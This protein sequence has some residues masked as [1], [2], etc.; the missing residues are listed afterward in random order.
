MKL[1]VLLKRQAEIDK[2]IHKLYP[3]YC[4]V[5]GVANLAKYINTKPRVMFVLKEANDYYES[6]RSLHSNN[7]DNVIHGYRNWRRSYQKLLYVA[8]G[9]LTQ[10][11]LWNDMDDL[12]ND[13]TID[14]YF[15]LDEIAFINLK[16][17]CGGSQANLTEVWEEY[18][19]AR[20][21]IEEQI[22]YLSPDIIINCSRI[23]DFFNHQVNNNEIRR[24][25][26]CEYAM[27]DGRLIINTYHP[28]ARVNEQW[29]VD[30]ILEVVRSNLFPEIYD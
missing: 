3:D 12:E 14:G 4:N 17:W 13:G 11:F 6:M 8:H 7:T 15:H 27:V 25:E 1:K 10:S 18:H 30:T 22:E 5:D 9:I 24:Y 2:K 20:T 16:K 23:V 26:F 29:Y 28:N 21:I 19:E